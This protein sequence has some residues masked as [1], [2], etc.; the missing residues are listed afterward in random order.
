MAEVVKI[1]GR[2]NG[3]RCALREAGQEY[4]KRLAQVT[5]DPRKLQDLDKE[6]QEGWAQKVVLCHHSGVTI[7]LGRSNEIGLFPRF[8]IGPPVL[9]GWKD[10]ALGLAK[11][12]NCE[13]AFGVEQVADRM[14]FVPEVLEEVRLSQCF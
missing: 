3:V 10:H 12:E 4:L 6:I 5:G 13:I 7:V 1:P 2:E 8:E 9:G 11:D 14:G